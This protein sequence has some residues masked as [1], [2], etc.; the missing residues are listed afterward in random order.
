M[1]IFA[2]WCLLV[3]GARA[4]S[5]SCALGPLAVGEDGHRG[6]IVAD[7][8]AQDGLEVRP[9]DERVS[10]VR[11]HRSRMPATAMARAPVARM[12][13]AMVAV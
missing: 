13:Q 7:S 5:R 3:L 10:F 12:Y 11:C 4:P 8:T 1:R 6:A 9:V 2:R